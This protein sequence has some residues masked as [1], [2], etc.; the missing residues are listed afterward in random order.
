MKLVRPRR[1]TRVVLYR[2]V[3]V[4]GASPISIQSMTTARAVDSAKTM[5]E[6]RAL[7]KAGCQLVRVAVK[8]AEDVAALGAIC[9]R[10]S[11]PVIA[12]VHFDYRLAV[13]S[14]KAGAAGLRINPGNI[15]G[16][17]KVERVV[18]AA[19]A[20]KIPIRVGVNSG[21]IERDLRGLLRREPARALH[22][23]AMRSARDIEAMGFRDLVFSLKSH[24]AIVTVEANRLFAAETDYP[25]HIGVTEAG[26]PLG[27]A[28]KSAVGLTLLLAAGIGDT[29][30]VSLSGDPVREIIVASAVLSSLGLRPDIPQIV[31]CPTCGRSWM[32]V[33][34]IAERVEREILG[35]HNGI[36]VAVMGC[37]V[38]GPGE[39]KDADIGIAGTRG[40]AVLFRKGKVVR[41]LR[42]DAGRRHGGFASEFIEEI[43]K[44][45]RSTLKR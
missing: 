38:N 12:D 24:D 15:G 8:D 10:S 30:R 26:P 25:L 31:S 39:A 2:G 16:M 1:K 11:I 21:S 41:R 36:R 4:G 33:A 5:R 23:S 18:E 6:I 37:E 9:A 45:S 29:V 17:E 28:A 19:G 40:G 35:L 7:A 3:T 34:G 42:P 14:V 32:D 27:G 22:E 20:A 44:I 13:A 43:R